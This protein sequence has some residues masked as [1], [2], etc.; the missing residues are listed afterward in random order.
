MAEWR[1]GSITRSY[2]QSSDHPRVF[3]GYCHNILLQTELAFEMDTRDSRSYNRPCSSK[4]H[5]AGHAGVLRATCAWLLLGKTVHSPPPHWSIRGRACWLL[6][7]ERQ[8]R[9]L[10]AFHAQVLSMQLILPTPAI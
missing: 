7:D 1:P 10:T 3:R 8:A 5:D 2:A 4:I 9:S 6:A